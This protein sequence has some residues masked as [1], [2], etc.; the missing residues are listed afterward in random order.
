MLP[1]EPG[2]PSPWI[3]GVPRSGTTLLRFMLDAHSQLAVPPETG[4]V[5]ALAAPPREGDDARA[6]FLSTLLGFES[7]PDFHLDETR[8]VERVGA[9]RPFT[10]SAGLRTFYR[11]YAERFDKERFGDK[12]PSYGLH[13]AAIEELLPEAHFVHIIRDGRDVAVSVRPLWF[14]PGPSFEDAARDWA[15]R[16]RRTRSEAA[17]CRKYLEVRYEDLVL[18]PEAVLRRVCDFLGLG[19]EPGMLA[20]YSRAPARLS[21]HEGRGGLVPLTKRERL[22]QQWMTQF[23]PDS[24]RI[25]R[26]RAEMSE[27][28]QARFQEAAS[29]MLEDLGYVRAQA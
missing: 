2:L 10:T 23:P 27:E 26:F 11:L 5:P 14:S 24:S 9:L 1:H 16:I 7:W 6:R 18:A 20:Y 21:E 4:F 13:L 29:G 17:R 12:T 3:V 8:L 22:E 19:F 25:G 28:A 15:D